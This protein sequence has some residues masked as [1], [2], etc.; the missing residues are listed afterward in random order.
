MRLRH[1]GSFALIA[2]AFSGCGSSGDTQEIE[3]PSSQPPVMKQPPGMEFE[4]KTDTIAMEKSRV[5]S[6]ARPHPR[7]VEVRYMVQVG[8][9]KDPHYASIVQSTA[10]DRYHLPTINDYNT[11]LALYQIRLGFFETRE[12]ASAF[13]Q[14]LLKEYPA[15]YKDAWVVQLKR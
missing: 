5:D 9:F 14:R 2:L 6:L 1:A 13:R 10:R 12:A 11:T 3:A 4:T 8:A 7:D 15:D